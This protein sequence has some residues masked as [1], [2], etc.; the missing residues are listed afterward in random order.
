MLDSASSCKIRVAIIGAGIAGLSAAAFLRKNRHCNIVV[1]ERREAD[2]QETSAALGLGANGISIVKQL[3]I[4]RKELR[5]VVGAGYRTYNLHEKEMS[6]SRISNG[7]NEDCGMW[8]VYR[9]DLKDALLRRVTSEDSDAEDVKLVYGCHIVKLD[10]E[11]GVI[12][13]AD[14]SSLEADLII[15]KWKTIKFKCGQTYNLFQ[16]LMAFA[17]RSAEPLFRHRTQSP[18]RAVSQCIDL[19]FQWMSS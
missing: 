8:L 3:G 11:A 6:K 13:F 14:G 17:P 7:Q 4:D 2:S 12:E 1:Y 15:G 10:P 19:S 18:C 5:G 16:A 9:Q